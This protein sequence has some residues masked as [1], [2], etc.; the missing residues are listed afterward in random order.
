MPSLEMRNVS[1]FLHPISQFYHQS[2]LEWVVSTLHQ[3]FSLLCFIIKIWDD[4]IGNLELL[5]CF[6]LLDTPRKPR[7]F[8]SSNLV[9][10][11]LGFVVFQKYADSVLVFYLRKRWILFYSFINVKQHLLTWS[12]L[13]TLDKSLVSVS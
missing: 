3:K 8:L 6:V 1:A 12:T 2:S 9:M 4:S 5:P 10:L 7:P 11:G 13:L